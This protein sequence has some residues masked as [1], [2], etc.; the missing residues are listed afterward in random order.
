MNHRARYAVIEDDLLQ[1]EPLVI[2]DVGPWDRHLTV[3]NDA[4]WVV[5]QLVRE[6][7]LPPGRR[8]FYIDTDGQKDELLVKDGRFA[9]FAPGAR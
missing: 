8:L 3:T 5:E 6:G 1:E 4:E 2:Q 9:G 7:H